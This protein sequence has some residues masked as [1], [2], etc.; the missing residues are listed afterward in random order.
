VKRGW[1][2]SGAVA[3]IVAFFVSGGWGVALVISALPITDP[4]SESGADLLNTVGGVLAGGV[5]AYIGAVAAQSV[6]DRRERHSENP[7]EPPAP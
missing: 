1:S 5:S 4:I 2:W 3:L 6:S 7:G